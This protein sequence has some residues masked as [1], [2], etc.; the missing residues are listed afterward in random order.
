MASPGHNELMGF[1]QCIIYHSSTLDQ[2]RLT[3]ASRLIDI[4]YAFSKQGHH[5]DNGWVTVWRQAIIWT[6]TGLSLIGPSTWMSNYIPQK[7][8]YVI[9]YS[10]PWRRFF[11][12]FSFLDQCYSAKFERFKQAY[13]DILYRWQLLDK[14]AEILK[15]AAKPAHQENDMGKLTHWPFEMWLQF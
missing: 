8:I 3:N 14:R 2:C 6:N 12:P 10:C 5:S 7:T 4:Y 11:S 15:Y 13:A 1:V 9:I